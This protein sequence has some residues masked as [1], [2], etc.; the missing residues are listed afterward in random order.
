MGLAIASLRV[1]NMEGRISLIMAINVS[2]V[3]TLE[4]LDRL[5]MCHKCTRG[6]D[7]MLRGG[8]HDHASHISY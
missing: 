7:H 5:I 3:A 6:T 1:P 4:A 2:G 8:G